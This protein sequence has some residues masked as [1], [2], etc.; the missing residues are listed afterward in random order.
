MSIRT[1]TTY[2][3]QVNLIQTHPKVV[4]FFGSPLCH[5]CKI[6][7]PA[8]EDFAKKYTSILFVKIN[9]YRVPVSNVD[10]VPLFTFYKNRKHVGNVVGADKEKIE[11][12]L[13][14][15]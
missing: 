3:E 6:I 9:S 15:L 10:G 13:K 11:S 12:T 1:I 14:S 8:I 5:Y 7:T 4:F 2:D